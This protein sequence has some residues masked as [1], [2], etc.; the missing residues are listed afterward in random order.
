MK[1][2]RRIV[3]SLMLA[4][5]MVTSVTPIETQAK[6]RSRGMSRP[7]SGFKS[8]STFKS[9][10]KSSSS[11]SKPK[12]KSYNKIKQPKVKPQSS[13]T[14]NWWGHGFGYGWNW[15][16]FNRDKCKTEPGHQSTKCEDKKDGK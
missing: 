2:V 3:M 6:V 13:T 9:A 16:W 11:F 15:G 12:P 7:S 1:I 8:T 14:Y 10:P 5:F 4:L